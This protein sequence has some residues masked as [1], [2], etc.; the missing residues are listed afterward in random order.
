MRYSVEWFEFATRDK[1]QYSVVKFKLDLIFIKNIES[2]LDNILYVLIKASTTDE[3]LRYQKYDL[4][5]N[6]ASALLK[7][8][9]AKY[10]VLTVEED[11]NIW[12]NL[13]FVLE[14]NLEDLIE[15]TVWYSV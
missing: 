1:L 3:E 4:I 15:W 2:I 5:N 8:I 7:A 13:K 11:F 9:V 12:E 14:G 6:Y 10:N